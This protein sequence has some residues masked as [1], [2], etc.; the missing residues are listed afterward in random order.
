MQ[1]RVKLFATL[2][3]FSPGG[4]AGTPFTVELPE[5]A[6]LDD[7]AK[8]LNLPPGDVKI[9]FVNAVIQELEYPLKDGD[10]VGFFPP[11]GGGSND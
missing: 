8:L 10:E 7:L 4:L 5:G 2:A 9:S 1:V 6:T 11:I 3:Q